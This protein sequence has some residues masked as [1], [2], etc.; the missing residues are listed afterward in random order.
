MSWVVDTC[1]LIDVL[2]EDPA[3]GRASAQ[4]LRRRL[5]EGLVTCPVTYVELAPAFDGSTGLQEEFLDGVGV[6]WQQDW[7]WQDTCVAHRAWRTIHA[8]R[9]KVGGPRRPVA[10]VMIGA[11]ATRF[12]GLITRNP[13]D[14][15]SVFPKLRLLAP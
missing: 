2:D 15:S 5:G 3:H 9:R 8:R 1:V 13:S 7:T 12:A 6:E 14:F 10:D 4:L 11:F